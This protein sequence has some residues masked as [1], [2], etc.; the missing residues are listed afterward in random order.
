MWISQQLLSAIFTQENFSSSLT[1]YTCT[2]F[3]KYVISNHF[4]YDC[5]SVLKHVLKSYDSFFYA[6]NSRK[7]VVGLI[8]TKQFM[9]KACRKLVACDEVVSCKSALTIIVQDT[10]LHGPGYG[11]G[12]GPWDGNVLWSSC[13][14]LF[15]NVE[16]CKC[17]QGFIS[18]YWLLR[19]LLFKLQ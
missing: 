16:Q 17:W 18:F 7:P 4:G 12:L 15:D 1:Q 5:C 11:P 8:Y 3:A 14:V 13:C 10:G 6:L 9:S 19:R 2:F